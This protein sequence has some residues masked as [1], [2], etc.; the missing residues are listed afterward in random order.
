[1]R[2]IFIPTV[3]LAAFAAGFLTSK[4]AVNRQASQSITTIHKITTDTVV[5]HDTCHIVVKEPIESATIRYITRYLPV[6]TIA[7]QTASSDSAAVKLPIT[8]KVYA[9]SLYRA[10]ISGFNPRLDSISIFPVRQSIT[11]TI[12]QTVQHKASAKR[13]GIG[14]TAGASATPKGISPSISIGVTYTLFTF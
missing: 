13:W 3:T 1:M 12:T 5:I 4:V 10:V 6:D 7:S 2:K 9:D 14:V 11:N 8:R